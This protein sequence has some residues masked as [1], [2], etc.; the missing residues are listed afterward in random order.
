M[1][2]PNIKKFNQFLANLDEHYIS[3]VEE[4]I[5]FVENSFPSQM[6]QEC[7]NDQILAILHRESKSTF[8]S[9]QFYWFQKLQDLLYITELLHNT[10]TAR[11]ENV[12]QE[13]HKEIKAFW[14]TLNFGIPLSDEL[15]DNV[16]KL[17]NEML[18]L[19]EQQLIAFYYIHINQDLDL[20]HP[21]LYFPVKE[22]GED[23]TRVS[24]ELRHY[25][26]LEDVELPLIIS[27][28]S[29]TDIHLEDIDLP[30]PQQAK[31]LNIPEKTA[32]S[33]SNIPSV[34]KLWNKLILDFD[35][36]SSLENFSPFLAVDSNAT[37]KEIFE[38]FSLYL[39]ALYELLCDDEWSEN[40]SDQQIEK[41]R[42]ESAKKWL[43]WLYKEEE[44]NSSLI[45]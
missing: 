12:V 11:S 27:Q 5:D 38:Q 10:Q 39:V 41:A 28:I 26:P 4:T 6:L 36:N 15:E 34:S 43:E 1:K 21:S 24:T 35:K 7:I 16:E 44:N 18:G 17:S 40:A 31:E 33:I 14:I 3:F 23:D 20:P 8:S 45:F 13:N 30:I 9:L 37:S 25:V 2:L 32:L 19:F 29:D 22:I 42:S